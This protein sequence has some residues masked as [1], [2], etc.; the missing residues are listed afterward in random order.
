[1]LICEMAAFY[2]EKGKTLIGLM[3]DI[4]S[5]F[6]LYLHKQVSF[7]CEGVTG[8]QRMDEIMASLRQNPPKQVAGLSVTEASD[9]LGSVLTDMASGSKRPITLPK[10][11]VLGFKLEGGASFIIR[12]SGTEPKIKVYINAKSNTN[13]AC[14]EQAEAIERDVT[15]LMGF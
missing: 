3:Q 11:N 1:M 6:G 9:Y 15:A 5:E 8:M 12:P 13:E 4:Y 7:T 2:K 14:R 10:S